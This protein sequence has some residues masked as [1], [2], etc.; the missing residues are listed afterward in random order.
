MCSG[1][2]LLWQ[3][4]QMRWD[5]QMLTSCAM[6]CAAWRDAFSPVRDRLDADL[7][8]L[9]HVHSASPLSAE[10]QATQQRCLDA[11]SLVDVVETRCFKL[12]PPYVTETLCA[13][14]HLLDVPCPRRPKARRGVKSW[15]GHLH[16]G[17]ATGDY[18][19]WQ[20]VKKAYVSTLFPCQRPD[21]LRDIRVISTPPRLLE[22]LRAVQHEPYL[23]PEV[24]E[25][26]NH[27]CGHLA[28]CV[29]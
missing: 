14:L 27:L 21:N 12:P 25:R 19:L 17:P 2:T 8:H 5:W 16:D 4:M 18:L 24:M 3:G 11:F 29:R 15:A 13:V 22:D 26:R 23:S 28:H 7:A 20:D 9:Q 1:G 10:L 6:V